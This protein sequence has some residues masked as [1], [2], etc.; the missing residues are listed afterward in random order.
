MTWNT[1]TSYVNIY[2]IREFD[3]VSMQWLW[4]CLY[5]AGEA[6]K[7]RYSNFQ[8]QTNSITHS[9][10]QS[11]SE[12]Q[13]KKI[14]SKNIYKHKQNPEWLEETKKKNNNNLVENETNG[15]L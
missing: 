6:G 5:L 10:I 8:N 9:D 11:K 3:G 12:I 14:Y 2:F 1:F 4:L 15:K 13:K 7:N